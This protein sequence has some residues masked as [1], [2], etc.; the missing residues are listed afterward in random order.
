MKRAVSCI[1]FLLFG[2][3]PARAKLHPVVLSVWLVGHTTQSSGIIL[4]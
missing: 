3:D 4:S 1:S 2:L